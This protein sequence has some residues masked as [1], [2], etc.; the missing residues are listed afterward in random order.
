MHGPVPRATAV[1]PPRPLGFT[2]RREHIDRLLAQLAPTTDDALPVLVFAV[3]GMGGIGKTAL[4]L[5]AAHR[6]CGQGWF[7]G[8]T[9][10][11]DLR[12][13][14]DDPV[15]ADQAVLA[16]LDALGVRGADLPTTATGQY[17]AYRALLAER[18]GRMLLI[19]DNASDPEQYRE[20]LPPTDRHRVLITSRDRH[21]T[22]PLRFVDLGTLAP[23]DSVALVVRALRITDEHDD[24][25]EREPAALRQLTDLCGHLPLAL[26][27]AAAMLRRRSHRDIAS[28]V[29]EIRTAG[30]ATA[31]L[32]NG[33]TG[34]DLYGRS[35][36]LRPVLE[37]SY[38]RLPDEQAR[39]L[40]L[41][42]L[43]PAAETGT[44]AVAA[45]ADM[46]VEDTLS[47]LESLA[48]T[49][50]VASVRPGDGMV[51]AGRWRT[52]DLVRAFGSRVVAED[53]ELRK[54]GKAARGRV[55]GFY[56]RWADAADNWL[57]WFPGQPVP[58]VF[59]GRREALE[60]LDRE[61]A[62]L[63]AAVGWAQ[64]EEFADAGLSLALNLGQYLH[65]RR[66]FD[67]GITVADTARSA[68]HRAGDRRAEAIAWSNLGN[69][70]HEAGRLDDAIDAHTHSRHLFRATENHRSEGMAWGHLGNA[71]HE[72]GRL[73]DAI[74]AHTRSRN[75]FQ[76]AEDHHSEG[77]AWTNLGN[78]LHEAGRTADAIDAFGKALAIHRDFGDRQGEGRAWNN[79][80]IA[81]HSGGRLDEAVEAFHQDLAISAEFEDW[82]GMGQTLVNLAL[83]HETAQRP[84]EA[85]T[86]YLEA[87]DAYSRAH[88]PGEA[89]EARSVAARLIGPP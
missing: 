32:D 55:M 84:S 59:E 88:A 54:E 10:F 16:L 53:T 69:A 83:L 50:L 75:V 68:A 31:V 41:L 80:G 67:D 30:D 43:A 36:V 37:T 82:Y 52:H 56:A 71:L 33:R 29:A 25:P 1:L 46:A 24:R 47:V 81:L 87:A 26:H 35:L 86:A 89:A 14:D 77:K 60:W 72:A 70:L 42:C 28:L 78:A 40:R 66:Y 63:V 61:R 34:T 18:E 73:D 19:L 20:L 2:G 15:T 62:G 39:L 4:A 74:D 21:D 57:R 38:E 8:G 49:H 48:A 11:V 13:Y 45:L 5:E 3:T 27:I 22:L 76:E 58:K 79:L 9:L 6:A 17:D 85:R 65:W 23:N 7:P 12:G 64:E 51:S 44:E